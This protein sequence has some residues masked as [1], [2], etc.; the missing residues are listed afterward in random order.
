MDSNQ[1]GI[2]AVILA[3]GQGKRFK[4]ST[5]KVLHR[6]AGLPLIHHVLASVGEVP[7]VARLIVVVGSGREAVKE[8]V[9]VK[10]P[11]AIFVEQAELL[12][13]GDA[14]RRCR[15]VLAGFR[16]IVMVL[17]GDGPLIRGETLAQ[18]AAQHASSRAD[19]TLLTAH[20][21]NP[22]GYGRIKRNA[23]GGFAGIVEE[24]D[25]SIEERAIKEVSSGIWCFQPDTLFPALDQIDNNN[26]QGEFYLPDVA[27][28][29][30][31]QGRHVHTLG[32]PDPGEI[33]GVNDRAQLA[34]ATRR[35]R[36]RKIEQVIAA[37]VTVEDPNTTYIDEAVVIGAETVVRPFSFIEGSTEIGGHCLIGPSC[38]V[39]DSVVEDGAE[40]TY[41]VVSGSHVGPGA[42]VG[43]FASLRPG[44]R[45]G[46]SSK[47]GTFVELKGS[48]IGEGSKVPHLSYVGDAEVGKG[49]NL[50]A[51]TITANYDSE[52][53]VKSKTTVGDG[54]FTGADTTLVAPV[55]V[56]DHAGTG[57]GSVVTKDVGDDEIVVG[58]PARPLRKRKPRPKAE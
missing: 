36:A 18:L 56:G 13:T 28:V 21:E 6:A 30:A 46:P 9:R 38:R 49:V 41:S 31:R 35:L 43:P 15:Q 55:R 20:L 37:G 44:T 50:G 54:A 39:V 22:S 2:A 51:G 16:G 8:A 25:A 23:D 3:A 10:R 4:S 12:G 27:A 47:A 42:A 48:I 1:D 57:A 52:S 11:D 45:L 26:A 24:T 58:V 33:E 34:E 29:L 53:K 40:I 17:P 19:A 7:G 5:P 32:A 14:V